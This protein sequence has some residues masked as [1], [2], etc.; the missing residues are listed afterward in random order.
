MSSSFVSNYYVFSNSLTKSMQ[1]GVSWEATRS[2]TIDEFLHALS[3][4]K[5][6]T[7]CT[8]ARQVFLSSNQINPVYAS[9]SGLLTI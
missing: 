4:R 3:T 5:F 1:G 6:F 7:T 8:S 2:P 9:L